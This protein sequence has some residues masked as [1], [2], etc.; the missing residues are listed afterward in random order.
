[1]KVIWVCHCTNPLDSTLKAVSATPSDVEI[2]AAV[3]QIA[4]E[5]VAITDSLTAATTAVSK[6]AFK[7][8]ASRQDACDAECIAEQIVAIVYEITSTIRAIIEELGLG[9][10]HYIPHVHQT[11]IT[12]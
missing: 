6:R 11:R 3:A 8:V 5:L 4:P 10:S 1:M 12:N 2:A 9:K 7:S